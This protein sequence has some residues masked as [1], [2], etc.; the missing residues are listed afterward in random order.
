MISN[1]LI[2]GLG[3]TGGRI[4]RALRKS[5]YQEFLSQDPVNGNIRYLYVNSNEEMMAADDLSWKVFGESVQLSR[6]SPLQISPANTAAVLA[7]LG[8]SPVICLLIRR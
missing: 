8:R 7:N 4:L 6:P 5:V 2:I 3:G 1:H